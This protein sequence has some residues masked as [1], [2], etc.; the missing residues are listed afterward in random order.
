MAITFEIIPIPLGSKLIQT[1]GSNDPD[2]L[3]D[4][5]CL[6][7]FQSN[8]TN[9]SKSGITLSAGA[10]LVSLTGSNSI[11]EATV[12]PPTSAGVV[13]FTVNQNAVAEGNPQTSKSIRISRS[14]P[15]D[16]AEVP[17]Q[18]F[19]TNALSQT[20]RG[21]TVSPTRILI[22]SGNFTIY[23]FSHAGVQ[24][25]SETASRVGGNAAPVDNIDF[26][27]GDVL[28]SPPSG[29]IDYFRY[30][31]NG[32]T[33]TEIEVDRSFGTV[34]GITHCRLGI[35]MMGR[36]G[37]EPLTRQF[38][39]TDIITHE[40]MGPGIST[41]GVETVAHSNDL[42]YWSSGNSVYVAEVTADNTIR[43][44][45]IL[46]IN[47]G[48]IADFAIYGDTLYILPFTP[49]AVYTLDI[50]PYRPL[51][52]NTKT[53][54][55]VQFANEGDTIDL[56][57]FCPDAHTL[58]FGVGFDKPDYLSINAD[59]ELVITSDAVSE[60]T[61]VL[62]KLTGINYIDS[63]EFEFYL[64]IQQATAPVWRDVDRLTMRA[65][66]SYDLFQLID[67][68]TI[69]FRSGRT[70][71]TN[72]TISNGVFRVDTVG[73]IASFT[74]RKGSRTAHTQ[75]HIDILQQPNED[76][77]SD[78]FE[79]RVEIAGIDVSEDVRDF[80]TV[81]K[82]LDI[83]T[84]NEYRANE[85]TL[86]LRSG[87]GNNFRYNDDIPD[88]FWQKHGL[89]AGGFRVP[90]T[91]YI[92]SLVNGNTRSHLLFSGII[93]DSKADINN[94]RVELR[95][96]DIS[97]ELEKTLVQDF[98]TLVK[99]DA[100][101]QKTD[102][103]SFQGVYAPESSLLPMQLGN[104]KAW[105]H[106][107][108]L[109]IRQLALPS[110]G[111]PIA[112]SAYMT[113]TDFFTS[114]GLLD[115]PPVLNFK[116]QHRSEDVRFLIDQIGIN[117]KVYN[118]EI[119]LTPLEL[120][121]PYLLNR[122]SIPFSVE[123]TRNTRLLTDWVY[124]SSNDRI[125]MLL[126]NPEGHIADVLVQYN[127]TG[128]AYRI[129]HTFDTDIHTHRI[130]RRNS[131]NYYIL[132]SAKI[133]Q[134]RS[135]RQLPRP[136]DT[137]GYA[138][139]SAAEGS[140]IKIYHYST[141][142]GRLTEHVAEDDTYPPQLGIH[143]WVG[144][145]N[146]LY[147]DTFEGIRPDNRSAFKWQGSY[148]YYR[149][150]KDG[151][152]GVA[153]VNTSGT[154]TK[155]I[156]QSVDGFQ[157]HL[158][159][160]FDINTSGA[161]YFVYA[162]G[163]ISQS[164]LV[165]KRRTSGGT[166][167]TLL[168]DTKALNALTDLDTEGGTYLGCHECVFHNSQLY[169]LAQ[170][171]RVDVNDSEVSW[172][173]QKSA[174]M[175]LYKCNV[176][177]GSPSLTVIETWDFVHHGGCNLIVYDGAVH[178]VEH[179]SACAVYKPYNPDLDGYWAD[180]EQEQTMGYNILPDP[181]GALKKINSSDE[182]ESL[183]NIWFQ[184][185]PYNVTPAQCLAF[186]DELHL[187]IGYGVPDEMLRYNSLASKP[188]NFQ[189]IVYGKKLHYVVPEFDPN[190][191][192]YA[193]LADIAKKTNATLSFQT[194]LIVISDR[195][196]FRA[197]TN[198]TTG[199]GTGN[200][201]FDSQNKAFPSTGYLLIGK[202]I[203]KYSGISGGAFTG[204]QRGVLGTEVVNHP[205]N[206]PIHYLHTALDDSRIIGGFSLST[207]SVRIHNVIRN[208]DNIAEEP[209]TQSIAAFGEL[210]YSLDLGLTHHELA[211]QEHIFKNYLENLKDPHPLIDL[212][213][214]PSFYLDLEQ[215]VG[216]R[217]DMLVYGV[218]IVNITYSKDSTTIQGRLL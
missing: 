165:I 34:D 196:P 167:S 28:V 87:S 62:V 204:I 129:L 19:L 37:R 8:V 112:D 141:S 31:I 68:D 200:L 139:D 117:K 179:P 72:S 67:A 197:R 143:Y 78:V 92:D 164:S 47:A 175:V 144:F 174:G 126:T 142:S 106:L 35:L 26:F 21:I 136:N 130:E 100:L 29:S 181:L 5:R 40:L 137:T 61:P 194:G 56:T 151:E 140:D 131:T 4:F 10:T 127:L 125:L 84:L 74:A 122:G 88:N 124:D 114:G 147:V 44:I 2:D 1:I 65:G 18:A 73:G 183:G 171:G 118:T 163:T 184:E 190:T 93:Q 195:D 210:P 212:T 113:S 214:K 185:R 57:Q 161:I 104:A 89:N 70:Q 80:P 22:A 191:S 217:Y 150:A 116:T 134:N 94:T 99:W 159:F 215:F 51:A 202:E 207:D 111:T 6:I 158:N 3:N 49:D 17:T 198:S 102:E 138:Y 82:S 95:C 60:T 16:D 50:R 13:T 105:S 173:Q 166:E 25:T 216:F 9:L 208:P 177:A 189:H 145:E 192:R 55:P 168:T 199:T 203:L 42:I 69:T 15:D 45:K 119:N 180:E 96:V 178:F 176:T 24:Q 156:G 36:G 193:L 52:K 23:P 146:G 75:I 46:N 86:A 97:T 58:T 218:Q 201:D 160:A 7:V 39:E 64:V 115:D 213:L 107:T 188:D 14:F 11:W 63:V 85:V 206:T 187:C 128:D 41:G 54:I 12:R 157:N 110:E 30:R 77:F 103:T 132:T 71:P 209:A 153:R 66:S 98:G 91:I 152:F 79:H 109:N 53:N 133:Q 172:S 32:T 182:V 76:N 155:M 154:M 123:D 148:L 83:V 135:A 162:T 27:N 169:I 33:L 120:R 149:Y 38:N 48:I 59:N 205:N 43:Y 20:L 81:S 108:Q 101:H 121:E 186:D 170:I 211:W 90:I